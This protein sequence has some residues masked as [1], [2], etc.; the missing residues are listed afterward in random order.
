LQTEAAAGGREVMVRVAGLGLRW[1]YTSGR[2]S[3]S[4][5]IH[6]VGY[7]ERWMFVRTEEEDGKSSRWASVERNKL[8]GLGEKI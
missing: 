6:Q 3:W 4:R 8:G 7:V 1:F 5:P 2:R